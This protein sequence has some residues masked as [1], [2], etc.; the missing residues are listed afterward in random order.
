MIVPT[1]LSVLF[2][3][4]THAAFFATL[5]YTVEFGA[6]VVSIFKYHVFGKSE[7]PTDA[8]KG[9]RDDAI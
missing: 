1:F 2:N 4:L 6:N 3:I 7:K 5:S 9:A 8:E